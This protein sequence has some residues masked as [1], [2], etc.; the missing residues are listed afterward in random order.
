MVI[1]HRWWSRMEFNKLDGVGPVDKSLLINGQ[2][3][4]QEVFT[5]CCAEGPPDSV[6][7]ALLPL[8]DV[9]PCLSLGSQEQCLL[10]VLRTQ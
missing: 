8:T 9:C 2:I 4:F 5:F 10:N 6:A 3:L 1:G 7:D